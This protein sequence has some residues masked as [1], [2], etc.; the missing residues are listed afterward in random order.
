MM[1]KGDNS[2]FRPSEGLESMRKTLRG[3]RAGWQITLSLS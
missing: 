1:F 2:G 3:G